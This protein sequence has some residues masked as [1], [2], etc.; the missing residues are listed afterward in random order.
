M[1]FT[2]TPHRE[3]GRVLRPSVAV[4]FR[5]GR[6]GALQQLAAER[7]FRPPRSGRGARTARCGPHDYGQLEESAL[8]VPPRNRYKI[9]QR[10]PWRAVGRGVLTPR[11]LLK[12]W[13]RSVDLIERATGIEPA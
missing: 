6:S 11:G 2:L 3:P 7:G 12:Q 10:A 13:V 5:L 4:A 8:R 9:A 1:R